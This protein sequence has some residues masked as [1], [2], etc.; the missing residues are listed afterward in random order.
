MFWKYVACTQKKAACEVD[1]SE[2]D[3]PNWEL[4]TDDIYFLNYYSGL[5]TSSFNWL[6]KQTAE[7]LKFVVFESCLMQFF[8]LF[9]FK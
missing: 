5:F 2:T 8:D 7:V 3:S 4:L 6:V 9:K 1:I